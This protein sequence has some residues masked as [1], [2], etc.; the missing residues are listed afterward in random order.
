MTA[1]HGREKERV[2]TSKHSKLCSKH[3]VIDI[4]TLTE[5]KFKNVRKHVYPHQKCS[6]LY[7]IYPYNIHS[8]TLRV[9]ATTLR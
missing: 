9:Y 7:L 2:K 6:A 4:K 8:R 3:L 1:T 5:H